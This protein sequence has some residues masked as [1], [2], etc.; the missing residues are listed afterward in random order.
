MDAPSAVASTAAYWLARSDPALKSIGTSSR[1]I[2]GVIG[3]SRLRP[4]PPRLRN[5]M[6]L[7]SHPKAEGQGRVPKKDGGAIRADHSRPEQRRSVQPH[8]DQ[9][10]VPIARNLGEF[11]PAPHRHQ[12]LGTGHVP[13]RV[14]EFVETILCDRAAVHFDPDE[15]QACGKAAP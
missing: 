5:W 2:A 3:V 6:N 14:G 9:P 13:Q 11:P 1:R 12:R 10:G 4:A 8:H 15:V 7:P